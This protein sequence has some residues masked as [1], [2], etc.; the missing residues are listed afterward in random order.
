MKRDF[1]DHS[2]PKIVN[3]KE[4]SKY[5]RKRNSDRSTPPEV[6]SD[7]FVSRIDALEQKF[8]GQDAQIENLKTVIKL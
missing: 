7:S 4:N 6:E 3:F 5:K 2:N 8:Q 1:S